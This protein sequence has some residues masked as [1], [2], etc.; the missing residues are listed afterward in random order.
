MRL[1]K[2]PGL[3]LDLSLEFGSLSE[4]E[5]DEYLRRLFFLR[6]LCRFFSLFRFPSVEARFD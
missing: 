4:L 3:D 2:H 5:L 6:L 1:S